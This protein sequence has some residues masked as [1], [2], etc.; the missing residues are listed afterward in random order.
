M[1][2]VSRA[3][4]LCAMACR[5]APRIQQI[6]RPQQLIRPKPHAQRAFTTSTIRWAREEDQRQDDAEEDD[7]GPIELKKLEAALAEASTPEGLKQLDQLAK[8]NGYNSI[9]HYLQNELEW[10]PGWASEDRSVLEDI[11]RDDKGE[12]PNKQS[13]WFDEEDPETNT[14]ELE[15][16]DEDDITSM[17]HGKLDEIRDMRQY[18]RLAVW[19]LP[20]L[21]TEYAKPFVPPSDNQVLR[22]RYT[23]YMGEFHPAEK[24]VVVQFAPD[25]LKLT[26]VQTEKLKKLAGPRYNPETEIIKMSSD[27]FE[28]QAQNKR[29]L[30]NL[31]DDLIAAAKDPK[32]TFEDIPLDTRH[33]KI[34]PKPQF[35]KE[36]R[37]SPERR[38]QLDAHRQRLAIEDAK[39]AESGRL[40]DGTQAI[41]EYLI[42]RAAEDQKKAKIAELVPATPGKS[43]GGS[44]ARR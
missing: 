34:Q 26:P 18:A 42:K 22:W 38:E 31:V 15:E 37:M 17:A 13:F 10:H 30:S 33:H 24:K 7:F 4:R 5:R 40:I 32:D 21:S 28:H 14:E 27:S 44:R 2:S 36:W 19:E 25:D 12:R 23:S 6:P 35:P 3:A 20:L 16:F 39:I 11:T 1:A 8:E 43:A 9:D 29:Y 41:D